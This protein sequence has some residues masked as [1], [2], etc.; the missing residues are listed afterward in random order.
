MYR[1][2][3]PVRGAFPDSKWQG[4]ALRMPGGTEFEDSQTRK[5]VSIRTFGLF[6]RRPR[7]TAKSADL[8]SDGVSERRL[9]AGRK[10]SAVPLISAAPQTSLLPLACDRSFTDQPSLL[11]LRWRRGSQ[12]LR[13]TK[14]PVATVSQAHANHEVE[15]VEDD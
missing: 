15:G 5:P 10:A 8:Q 7:L 4:T 11:R 12:R 1:T 13:Y 2:L 6:Q 3:G 9:G 14:G